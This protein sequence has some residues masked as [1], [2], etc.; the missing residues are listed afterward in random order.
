VA[1][2]VDEHDRRTVR[3]RFIAVGGEVLTPLMRHS[4]AEAFAAPVF[5]LYASQE[6]VFLA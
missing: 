6:F 1:Q 2:V 4:I 5:D 3:P